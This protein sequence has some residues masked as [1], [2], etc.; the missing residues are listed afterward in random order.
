MPFLGPYAL[1]GTLGLLAAGIPI[2]LHFFYRSRYRRVPWAAVEFLRASLEQTSRRLKFQQWLLLLWRVLLLLVLAVALMRPYSAAPGS[3]AGDAVDAV[4]LVDV[5]YSMAARAGRAT[6]LDQAKAAASAVLDQLPPGST[7][8]VV[9]ISDRARRLG[10]RA[11]S[12]LDQARQ[13]LEQLAVEDRATDFLPGVIEAEQILARGPSPN[14]ELY[15]F[16]DMQ[17]L[18]WDQQAGPLAARLQALSREAAIHLVRCETHRPRNVALAGLVPP[19]G[20]IRA[21]ERLDWSVLVR[22]TGSDPVRDATVTLAIEGAGRESRPLPE[23]APQSTQAVVVPGKLDQ[24]GLG[25]V[26]VTVQGDD[27]GPDNHLERIVRAWERV[28]VLVLDGGPNDRE[29]ERAA[30][31][32]L[33]HALRPVP[34]PESDFP[35][36]PRVV[37]ASRASPEMLEGIDVCVLVDVPLEASGEGRSMSGAFLDRL[38]GFVRGGGG[39]MIFAGP[40]VVPA[41]YNRLLGGSR[42]LL[43]GPLTGVW[44]AALSSP[45]HPDPESVAK[46]SVLAG[47]RDEPLARLRQVEVLRG[48]EV[49]VA[50]G[51]G[52]APAPGGGPP[53][54]GQPPEGANPPGAGGGGG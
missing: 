4:L 40:R 9:T 43:P 45:E 11:A 2:A 29:P 22:N 13:L 30:S 7:V 18:G 54:P 53:P 6:R 34:S 44:S 48:V 52:A 1:L 12:H 49:D 33:V 39:L 46:E 21:G 35:I 16:S 10:P 51:A 42:G 37:S 41:A 50:A 47:F 26:R 23:L 19:P 20:I 27:L 17:R 15:L 38:A 14:K 8:Q 25:V 36:E 32:Y 24:P 5:S 28:R 3:A 31:Y